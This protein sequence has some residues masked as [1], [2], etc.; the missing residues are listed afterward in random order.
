MV[1]DLGAAAPGQQR[2]HLLLGSDREELASLAPEILVEAE[3]ARRMS[4]PPEGRPFGREDRLLEAEEEEREVD[5]LAQAPHASVS[6]GPDLRAHVVDDAPPHRV[7]RAREPEVQPGGID[8]KEDRVGTLLER[9]PH[10]RP[11]TADGG[12]MGDRAE[13]HDRDGLH[14]RHRPHPGL[15]QRR[16]AEAHRLDVGSSRAER[17]QACRSQPVPRRVAGRDHELHG[18]QTE[19][20]WGVGAMRRTI[21][22]AARRAS[23]AVADSAQERCGSSRRASTWRSSD[24]SGSNPDTWIARGRMRWSRSSVPVPPPWAGARR[25]ASTVRFRQSIE[26][27]SLD[28]KKRIFRIFSREIRL[29]VR[30]ATHPLS[31]TIR[32]FAMSMRGVS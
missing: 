29:A 30:F 11:R 12:K 5:V 25:Y 8:R 19:T 22:S 13:P 17:A 1:P 14:V 10:L 3:L 21:R 32:A 7:R 26:R 15:A 9:A 20:P 24:S 4:H 27:Y 28:S 31:K 2:D 6:P 23:R 16:P 18:D